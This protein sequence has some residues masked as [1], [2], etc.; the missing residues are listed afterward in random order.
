M[1]AGTIAASHYARGV[2]VA[3]MGKLEEAEAER[4]KFYAA[5][6]NKFKRWKSIAFLKMSCMILS[7]IPEFLA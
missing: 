7:T 6:E 5:L 3:V 1:Y 2:A 4:K